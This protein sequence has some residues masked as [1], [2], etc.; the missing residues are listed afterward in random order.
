[1]TFAGWIE[2]SLVL[3]L[4]LGAAWPLGASMADVFEGRRSVLSPMVGPLERSFYRLSGVDP[5]KEQNWLDYTISM[6]VFTAGCFMALYITQRLQ[7]VLPFNPQGRDAVPP[8]LAFNTAISFITNAN[9]QAYAGETTMSHFTQMAGLTTHNFLD[10]AVAMALAVGL[11]RALA[12]GEAETIGN[13]WVD[14]T[15]A[16]LYVL[17]PISILV[18]LIF[19]A[20][21]IPQTLQGSI[22]ATTLEGARQS[23]AIG[24]VASQEA[25]KL[26]GTNGGGFFNANSAHPFENPNAW[27]NMLECWCQLVL[28]V[29]F[30]F[31]FGRMVDD[32]RQ[33]R[34]LLAAMA[35][36]FIVSL[37][38]LYRA[39]AIGN[40]L[41]T[42]IGVDPS[43][44]NLEGKELRFSQ[45]SAA[46]FAV[47]TTG[48]GTGAANA[49]F[50]SL[51]P[52]GGLV[53]LFN[54]LMGCI[55]PGGVGTGLYG[56]LLLAILAVFLAGLM[57]GRTPEYLGK[58][59]EAREIKFAMLSLLLLPGLVLGFTAISV[60]LRVA[61]DSLGNAGPHGLSEILYAYAST[62]ADNGS[63][64]GG[65]AVN[66]PWFNTT[67][68]IVLLLGRIGSVVPIM[69]IAGSLARK[70]K[71]RASAGTFPTHGPLFVTLLLA[72][73]LIV[74]LLQFFP[75]I[76]LGPLLEHVLMDSGRTF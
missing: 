64:F 60:S 65:L 7:G 6:I 45:A 50:D 67:T 73:V 14:M 36:I 33:G 35:F 3:A 21:G 37:A 75:V 30:V 13:F 71:I 18:A 53:P 48:T 17:L 40:P 44:G 41:L 25:I 54:L 19:V 47:A 9:W 27:S 55:A 51:T 26:I 20:L 66:T 52:I 46:L 39:E 2:I 22:E 57:V 5:Q 34:G 59:I 16:T 31:T 23:I 32:P 70:K 68:G 74:T 76:T 56:V 15:R 24:P 4:V 58:K 1:M 29:A 10:T 42:A 61:L 38:M 49:T 12:R 62:A 43:D 11:T 8:D 72:V 63:A 69:A 28:A